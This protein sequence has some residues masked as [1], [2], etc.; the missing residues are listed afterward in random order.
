MKGNNS[1]TSKNIKLGKTFVWHLQDGKLLRWTKDFKLK[2]KVFVF[3]WTG[4]KLN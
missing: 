1:E 3:S 2:P 4:N